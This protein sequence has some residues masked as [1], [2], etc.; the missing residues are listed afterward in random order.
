MSSEPDHHQAPLAECCANCAT[1]LVGDY[2][3]QC[4]QRRLRTEDRHFVAL[5]GQFWEG[6]TDLDSRFWRS[7]LRLL[8]RPGLLS[9]DYI[10][11]RRQHWM[12]PVGLFLLANVLYF[13]SP[14]LTD[15]DLP[16]DNQVQGDLALASLAD[17]IRQRPEV[18]EKYGH[19]G[20]QAHSVIT[21][22][23]VRQRIAARQQQNPSY[24]V[25]DYAAPRATSAVC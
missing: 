2:C 7:F 15:F 24:S 5:I 25:V 11:G 4:G 3:H 1:A 21:S 18:Q 16:F 10:A 23:W 12:S 20:G 19:W 22:D 14:G 13:F 9:R 8:F 6:L 17:P